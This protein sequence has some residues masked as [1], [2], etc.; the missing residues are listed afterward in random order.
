MRI[1]IIDDEI[2]R[3]QA[4]VDMLRSDRHAVEQITS[5]SL[6]LQ[7][8][9]SA[10]KHCDLI[11][12]DVMMPIDNEDEFRVLETEFGL[13]TGVLLLKKIKEIEGFNAPIIVLTANYEIEEELKGQ[14][15]HFLRKPVPYAHLKAAIDKL[16]SR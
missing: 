14:V 4:T 15:D 3:M 12:L 6:A 5:P 1:L 7:K 11:I 8:L 13:R 10:P 16:Y 2:R 9:R